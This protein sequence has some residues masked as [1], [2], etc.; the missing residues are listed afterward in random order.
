MVDKKVKDLGKQIE[1]YKERI[2]TKKVDEVKQIEYL[3]VRKQFG[4]LKNE[5][6]KKKV[7]GK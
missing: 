2:W 4:L 7:K 5:S 6:K 1:N 3:K